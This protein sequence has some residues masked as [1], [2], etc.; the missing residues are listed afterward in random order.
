MLFLSL[1]EGEKQKYQQNQSSLG[2][3][4]ACADLSKVFVFFSK[5]TNSISVKARAMEIAEKFTESSADGKSLPLLEA[6][7]DLSRTWS[8]HRIQKN[9]L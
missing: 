5:K 9:F 1:L 7:Y 4:Q 3:Q 6:A 2:T 8:T